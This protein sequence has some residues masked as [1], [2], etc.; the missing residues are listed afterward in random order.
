MIEPVYI[1]NYHYTN[2][3]VRWFTTL[4]K[5]K[6]IRVIE[7]PTYRGEF[8]TDRWQEF[9][10]TA[11]WLNE[12]QMFY[13][14]DEIEDSFVYGPFVEGVYD[15]IKSLVSS[16]GAVK[17]IFVYELFVQNVPATLQG[18]VSFD[19]FWTAEDVSCVRYTPNE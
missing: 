11:F 7:V 10:T 16:W 2:L 18:F 6:G 3:L 12:K 14:G 4:M 8:F 13:D 1:P 19:V 15:Q 17:T 9:E 5:N